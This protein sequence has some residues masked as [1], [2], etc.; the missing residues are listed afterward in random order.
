MWIETGVKEWNGDDVDAAKQKMASTSFWWLGKNWVEWLPVALPSTEP[1]C[2]ADFGKTVAR[3]NGSFFKTYVLACNFP[4][5]FLASVCCCLSQCHT[6]VGT[7]THTSTTYKL[8][9]AWLK[10]ELSWL[11]VW[12]CLPAQLID[13]QHMH[14]A[15]DKLHFLSLHNWLCCNL[16]FM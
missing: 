13:S 9:S 1:W 12:C 2:K 14:Y 4:F 3:Q 7:E 5:F 8:W 6:F 16:L 11:I 10:N 15:L